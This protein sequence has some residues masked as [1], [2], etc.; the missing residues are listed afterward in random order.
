MFAGLALLI[1]IGSVAAEPAFADDRKG[2][3]RNARHRGQRVVRNPHYVYDRRSYGYDHRY[4]GGY[5]PPVV[6][7]PPAPYPEISI[8]IPLRFR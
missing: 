2:G 5:P 4:Y 8:I 6:Y 1:A 7:A 3:D